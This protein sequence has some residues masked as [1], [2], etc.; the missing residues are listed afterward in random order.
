MPEVLRMDN[1]LAPTCK[2]IT[3]WADGVVGLV[4]IPLTCPRLVSRM[5]CESGV[6]VVPL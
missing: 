1:G 3:E 2:A 4:F 5:R 6:G